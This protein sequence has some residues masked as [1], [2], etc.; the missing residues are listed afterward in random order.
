MLE[1]RRCDDAP[2]KEN[3]ADYILGIF[4]LFTDI[5]TTQIQFR[6]EALCKSAMN[7]KCILFV[8]VMPSQ[9]RNPQH[10][11][12]TTRRHSAALFH[13]PHIFSNTP[14]IVDIQRPCYRI[15]RSITTL[16][17]TCEAVLYNIIVSIEFLYL[18]RQIFNPYTHAISRACFMRQCCYSS[19]NKPSANICWISPSEVCVGVCLCILLCVCV[20]ISLHETPLFIPADRWNMVYILL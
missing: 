2:V 19:E 8:I 14:Q 5:Q 6:T 12:S 9:F 10:R 17:Q 7:L 20:C 11:A 15:H 18:R 3:K 4:I 1:S 16:P 13:S